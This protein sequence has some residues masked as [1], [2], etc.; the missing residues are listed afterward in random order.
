MKAAEGVHVCQPYKYMQS[1]NRSGRDKSGTLAPIPF[2]W[3]LSV[4]SGFDALCVPREADQSR[5]L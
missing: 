2:R 1:H 4:P 5:R 3:E